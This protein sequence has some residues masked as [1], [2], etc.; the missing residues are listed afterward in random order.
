MGKEISAAFEGSRR[1]EM[2]RARE[3]SASPVA[4]QY[5]TES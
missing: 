3:A 5:E 1:I 2:L 4:G